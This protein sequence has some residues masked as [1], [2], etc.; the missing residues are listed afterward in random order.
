MKAL[1]RALQE[2]YLNVIFVDRVKH[3]I[4]YCISAEFVVDLTYRHTN[5]KCSAY[6]S[7]LLGRRT[8]RAPCGMDDPVEQL[9]DLPWSTFL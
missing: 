4:V 1:R 7:A 6:I 5:S 8:H 9:G 2:L 3:T